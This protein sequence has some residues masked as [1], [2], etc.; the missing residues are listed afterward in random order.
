MLPASK[1]AGIGLHTKVTILISALGISS[2]CDV[3]TAVLAQQRKSEFSGQTAGAQCVIEGV[4]LRWCPAGRF[5]MGSPPSE[6]HRRSDEDQ[7]EVTLSKGF[8]IGQYEVTQEQWKR[9]AGAFP[10]PMDKGSGDDFPVYW[11]NYKEAGEFCR[12]LTE[13]AWASGELD[14]NWVFRLPTEAQWEYACRA[15]TT[16]AT[17]FG[18]R[19]NRSDANF[20]G[21]PYNGGRDGPPLKSS[22]KV[23]SYPGNAWGIHDMHGN[24]FEWCMDW[25]HGKLPGG[26]DPDLS[27][28]KGVMN[29]DGTYSRVRRGG[30]WTDHGW[31]CRS[32]LRLRYEPERRS[33]HI[34]FRVVAVRH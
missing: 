31:F 2:T 23:G 22:S 34:G 13:K 19:L 5:R 10:L 3:P 25:Y 30:A 14:R 18:E 7:V 26:V 16:S 8:W 17:S 29:R 9:I 20:Q 6:P 32:A 1:T 12:R 28:A 11:V 4:R 33:D 21:E 24:V 27:A 15:G